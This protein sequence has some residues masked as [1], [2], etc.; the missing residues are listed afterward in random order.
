MQFLSPIAKILIGGKKVVIGFNNTTNWNY[1]P[2][3]HAEIDAYTKIKN[4][5]NVPKKMDL[6]VV[7]ITNGGN[8]A[9]SR[10]CFHCINILA[11]SK[12]NIKNIYY[13]TSDRTIVCEKFVDLVSSTKKYVTRGFKRR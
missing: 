2:T 7:R 12:L 10:P 9:E 4:Y 8:L 13:S 5:K 1:M 6:L 3:L 11:K